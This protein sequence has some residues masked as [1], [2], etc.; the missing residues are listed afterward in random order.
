MTCLL[1]FDGNQGKIDYWSTNLIRNRK[2]GLCLDS[3]IITRESEMQSSSSALPLSASF[4]LQSKH[5]QEALLL[6][7][8]SL[9]LLITQ[10]PD[11]LAPGGGHRRGLSWSRRVIGGRFRVF[12]DRVHRYHCQIPIE[13]WIGRF[14]SQSTLIIRRRI[15]KYLDLQRPNWP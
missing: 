12:P 2:Y 14:I 15:P 4:P 7:R 6:D 3:Y 11:D 8:I 9:S 13:N 5:R 1:T 10:H